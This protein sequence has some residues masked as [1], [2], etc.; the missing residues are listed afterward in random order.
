[1]IFNMKKIPYLNYLTITIGIGVLVALAFMA[2]TKPITKTAKNVVAPEIEKIKSLTNTEAQAAE[3]KKLLERVGPEET[4]EQMFR[5][6]LPFTGQTHLLIHVIGD[7]VYEKLGLDG[8]SSCKDYFLSACY[9]G[10]II[11]TLG[12][13]GLPGM[14]EVMENCDK[15]PPG[16]ASQCAHG[17][18]HGFVAW[19]DYDLLKGLEMC[20]ELGSKTSNFAYFNCY[21]GVFMENVWGVHGGK[22]SEKRWVKPDDIN[23][24][25]NDPR[26]PEKYL[27]GCWANQAT[28]I[29]QYYKGDLKKT[30][31]ACEAVFKEEYRSSCYNNLYRQIHPLTEGSKDKVLALCQNSVGKER[32]G[33]CVLTN[34]SAYWGVGDRKVP[35]EICEIVPEPLKSNCFER[36]TGMVGFYYKNSPKDKSFYC[37]KISSTI[38]KNKCLGNK[39]YE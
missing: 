24:P 18:G 5:S 6:G 16:V 1:M 7:Y 17:A 20:D 22:P 11:N 4:Q 19:H 38:F 30:A 32:Q 23:Y 37:S 26:I 31:Q 2:P 10:F 29:Y 21:D 36:L 28:L 8:L 9:H 3:L 25:C 33:E 39:T 15:A 34:M 14:V 35:Y 27:T 13:S 12:D